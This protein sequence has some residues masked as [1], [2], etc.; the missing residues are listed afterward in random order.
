ME[1]RASLAPDELL[2]LSV[3][4]GVCA[5]AF[6]NEPSDEIVERLACVAHA[7]GSDAFDGIAVDDALRQRY[8]DR[9]FVPTSSL[10]VP[11]FESSVR[12]A[13][14][15]DGR[16]RYASTKGPQADHVLG[17]YRAI[18]FNYRLLEGFGPAVAA[19]RPDALAAELAFSAFLARESAEMACE[20]PDASRRSAQLLDQFSSEHVGAWVGKAARCLFL[21]ADDLYA[22]TAKLACDAI[23]SA[24]AVRL[25]L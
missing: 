10:Y 11:L 14:E 3:A 2:G 5:Q 24:G 17:C 16:F 6:L 22:R 12:G 9:L 19:L 8:Y 25:D 23:A 20:D 15:E 13:I 18:G 21:G 4:V 7:Y 1:E